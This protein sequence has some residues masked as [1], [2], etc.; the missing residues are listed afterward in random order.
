[1]ANGRPQ[2]LDMERHN[3]RSHHGKTRMLPR[4]LVDRAVGALNGQL[5]QILDV[6]AVADAVTKGFVEHIDRGLRSDFARFGAAHSVRH[7]KNA[8]LVIGQKRI[9]IH[10]PFLVQAAVADR[11]RGDL[12]CGHG[13][14][15][16][17]ASNS[18]WLSGSRLTRANA[19]ASC[20]LRC[21]NAINI[22]SMAK[23]VIRLNPPWLTNGK[24]IPVIGSAR[25][26]PP[27]FTSAWTPTN[28]V[29]PAEQS[30]VNIS[31]ASIE[32]RI[33]AIT[34]MMIA[35]TTKIPPARPISSAIA[36]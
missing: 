20:A 36:A 27:I 31:R 24:V 3:R 2:A 13:C 30:L 25:T 33:P 9:F 12:I 35:S 26:I 29:N 7:G 23:L 22:P 16:S 28:A 8:A 11:R 18:I 1:M 19:F 4:H 32:V 5:H 14:A 17:T 21:E 6:I 34:K 15:H 10:W